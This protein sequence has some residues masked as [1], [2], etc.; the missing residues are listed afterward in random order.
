MSDQLIWGRVDCFSRTLLIIKNLHGLKKARLQLC[1]IVSTLNRDNIAPKASFKTA[2]NPPR[3]NTP[4]L[5]QIPESLA[6]LI[7]VSALKVY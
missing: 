2:A 4:C 7:I 1:T 3:Q 6:E 5:Y